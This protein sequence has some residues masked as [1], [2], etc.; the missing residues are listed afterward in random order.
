METRM[1]SKSWFSPIISYSIL[2]W[3]IIC[4]IGTWFVILKYGILLEGLIAIMTTFFFAATLWI[5]PLTGLILLSLYVT[6]SGE[7]PP[8]VMFKELIRKGMRRS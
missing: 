1:F 7:S 3:T 2:S 5:I 6:P 4:F 8:S